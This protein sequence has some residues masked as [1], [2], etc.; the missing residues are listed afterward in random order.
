MGIEAGFMVPHPPLIVHEVG[1]GEERK[2]QSTIDA[3]IEVAKKISKI[4]P[5]TIVISSPHTELYSNYFH[6]SPGSTARGN[7]GRFDAA[8]VSFSVDYDKEFVSML[9]AAAKAA[10]LPAG[11]EGQ[12]NPE[13][14]HGVMVP[15][16]FVNKFYSG[17]RL[18]RMG[19]S[20][21]SPAEHYRIGMCVKTAAEELNR[22]VVYIASGDLSHK[23]KP[24]GPYGFAEEGPEY[25]RR[26]M[27]AMQAGDFAALFDFTREFRDAAA[28]CGHSSFL[29][30]A[31]AFDGMAVRAKKLSHEGPFGVGYGL[32][33]FEPAGEDS[34]RRFL[35]AYKRKSLEKT[36]EIRKKEDPYVR[37]ARMTVE[38]Y[39]SAGGFGAPSRESL[40]R[41]GHE[42]C[43]LCAVFPD[44]KV[45]Q[46]PP[47]MASEK[48]GVFVSLHKR[49]KDGELRGCIGT[50]TCTTGCT[51]S[52]IVSNA[53][54]ACSRDPRFSPVEPSEL[55]S[56]VYSVDVLSEPEPI[57]S[58]DE[59]DAK[60]YGVICTKGSRRGL[61][62]PDLDGVENVQEQLE[63]ACR[64]GGIRLAE[65]PDIERFEV[66]R[67][68]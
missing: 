22:S 5:E 3:Y 43:G 33:A 20:G 54:S 56:L 15:L 61:L 10:G 51:A 64:K 62:L 13:L 40:P 42:K 17:Y 4:R 1:R 48:A 68:F 49:H 34:S 21:L 67:H 57:K 53:V 36:A 28:E 59:L 44:G 7:F 31:G 27:E 50:I 39:V 58:L 55:A 46:L 65:N 16:Y 32:C 8:E 12:K 23:L 35:E 52:E 26:V 14:D 2:I 47:E 6:I 24:D 9:C 38:A 19:L 18:V 66:T 60:R 29:M 45:L 41:I 37:L 25:D 30:M 63:I 11:T